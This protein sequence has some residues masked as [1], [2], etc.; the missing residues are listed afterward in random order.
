MFRVSRL[1]AAYMDPSFDPW[2]GAP[3]TSEAEVAFDG[4]CS[5][6]ECAANQAGDRGKGGEMESVEK[7]K[8][9]QLSFQFQA[10]WR[11]QREKKSLTSLIKRVLRGRRSIFDVCKLTIESTRMPNTYKTMVAVSPINLQP[12]AM[13]YHSRDLFR[14]SGWMHIWK[15]KEKSVKIKCLTITSQH[16]LNELNEKWAKFTRMLFEMCVKSISIG[17]Q[18]SQAL[19]S[20]NIIKCTLLCLCSQNGFKCAMKLNA[21]CI[22]NKRL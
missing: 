5:P 3:N 4:A 17:Q 9:K 21:K 12:L 7:N 14:Y 22:A 10:S 6:R 19:K 8:W 2:N 20:S 18:C 13:L 16:H 15:S 1:A 11:M